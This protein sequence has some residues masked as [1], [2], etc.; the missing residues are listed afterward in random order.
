ML[1]AIKGDD[2]AATAI[3]TYKAEEITYGDV[4][5][6]ISGSG[7]LSP[8]RSETISAPYPECYEEK[9]DETV[10]ISDNGQMS[11]NTIE[12]KENFK[13]TELNISAGDEFTEGDVLAVLKNEDDE[14]T[15]IK[16][17]IMV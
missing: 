11:S 15:K 1:K 9:T 8:I 13:I 3:T 2:V 16:P 4:D 10:D 14:T 7:S 5:T 17:N 6:T 12:Q